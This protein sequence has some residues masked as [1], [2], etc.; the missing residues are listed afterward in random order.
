MLSTSLHDALPPGLSSSRY[1]NPT[2]VGVS[3]IDVELENP[4]PLHEINNESTRSKATS[5]GEAWKGFGTMRVVKDMTS[6]GQQ[7]TGIPTI[8]CPRSLF[9]YA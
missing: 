3:L 9:M 5:H 2:V 8:F 1:D 7:D 6:G 4:A